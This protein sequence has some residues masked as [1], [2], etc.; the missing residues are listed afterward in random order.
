MGHKIKKRIAFGILTLLI[1]I[2]L[3]FAYIQT[4]FAE[5]YFS[6]YVATYSQGIII[7][8]SYDSPKISWLLHIGYQ[9]YIKENSNSPEGEYYLYLANGAGIGIKR[10]A[11]QS[12]LWLKKAV[13][14]NYPLALTTYSLKLGHEHRISEGESYLK[15]AAALREP[16]AQMFIALMSNDE[17]NRIKTLT[18]LAEQNNGTAQAILGQFY[19]G[20]MDPNHQK[21]FY[22]T[23]KAANNPNTPS[24][25]LFG[26]M[27]QLVN[28]YTQGI[29]T[30]KNLKAADEWNQKI[31][32]L[33]KQ[34]NC[35]ADKPFHNGII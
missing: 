1:C 35:L 30:S 25:Y 4:Y 19:P 29:G 11:D 34:K 26:A 2:G 6:H 12:N 27:L 8:P 15:K 5:A 23:L 22:W 17:N 33:Q 13:N 24:F 20:S 31:N 14:N 3:T 7:C 18:D 32:A 16:N 9:K 10:N 28:M 21:S